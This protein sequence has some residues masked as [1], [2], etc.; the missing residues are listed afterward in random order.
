MLLRGKQ[1]RHFFRGWLPYLLSIFA[2]IGAIGVSGVFKPGKAAAMLLRNAIGNG[3]SVICRRIEIHIGEVDRF[4]RSIM[5]FFP[6]QKIMQVH[7]PKTDSMA[8]VIAFGNRK[9]QM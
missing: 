1:R 6:R 7:L 5:N 8:F 2:E 3:K 9:E 4:R